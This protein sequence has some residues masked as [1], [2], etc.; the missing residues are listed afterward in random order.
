MT[1][2]QQIMSAYIME[3]Y[4]Y[5]AKKAHMLNH[6]D[7]YTKE[8]FID[9]NAKISGAFQLFEEIR[10]TIF[11]PKIKMLKNKDFT[12]SL[13]EGDNIFPCMGSFKYRNQVFPI[14]ADDYGM[15]DFTEIKVKDKWI[16]IDT[17][18]DW[19]YAIDLYY[20]LDRF[21]SASTVKECEQ[22]L[23]DLIESDWFKLNTKGY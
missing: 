7:I 2:Q 12:C 6:T 11:T 18:Y 16:Q 19:Y 1:K 4:K 21:L 15:T 23:T 8:D 22:I 17:L 10:N 9:C 5:M 20:D 13:N 14:Y 3:M